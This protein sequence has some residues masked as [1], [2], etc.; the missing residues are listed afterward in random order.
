MKKAGALHS[1]LQWLSAL[2]KVSKP[3]AQKLTILIA[4]DDEV[5]QILL[6]KNVKVFCKRIIQVGTGVEAVKACRENPD[7]DLI[8]MDINMPDMNGHEA[9]RHIRNFNQDVVIIAQTAYGM[10]G[11]RKKAMAAGCTNYLPKPINGAEL[12]ALVHKYFQLPS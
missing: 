3:E 5:S 1:F 6:E 8:L 11:D 7:I 4:E 9:T 2:K 10:E 12:R